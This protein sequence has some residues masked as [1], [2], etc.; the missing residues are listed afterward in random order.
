MNYDLIGD[1][2]GN[3]QALHGLLETMGYSQRGSVWRAPK[4]RKA[5]FVG[6]LIDRGPA[7]VKVLQTVRDM[8][9]S[10]QALLVLGNHEL[11]AIAL[12]DTN[13]RTGEYYRPRTEPRPAQ[14]LS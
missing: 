6:D 5:V 4:G 8:V 12:V 3:A 2:H 14:S 10:D 9:E 13:P 7:Q 11:N 1:I